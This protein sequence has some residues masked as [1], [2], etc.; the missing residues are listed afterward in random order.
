VLCV[1][2][3]GDSVEEGGEDGFVDFVEVDSGPGRGI[4]LGRRRDRGEKDGG[5]SSRV[6]YTTFWQ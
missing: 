6:G 1:G 4:R 2:E 3:A 5:R